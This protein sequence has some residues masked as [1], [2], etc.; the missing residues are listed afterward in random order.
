MIP[1]SEKLRREKV[2]V[3]LAE[4][5]ALVGEIAVGLMAEKSGTEILEEMRQERHQSLLL[6]SPSQR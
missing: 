2:E 1:E 4:L 3:V 6:T 5:D